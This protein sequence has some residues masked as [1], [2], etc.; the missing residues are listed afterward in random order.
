MDLGPESVSLGKPTWENGERQALLSGDPAN[1][2][3]KT[4]PW[5]RGGGDLH[6]LI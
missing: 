6:L 1:R 3:L 5:G 2:R 4:P